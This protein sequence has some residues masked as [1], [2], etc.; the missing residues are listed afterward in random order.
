MSDRTTRLLRNGLAGNQVDFDEFVGRVTPLL[1][2][3]AKRCTRSLA[4]RGLDP[5]DVVQHV[6]MKC[7]P[8]LSSIQPKEGRI[9]PVVVK[10]LSQAIQRRARDLMVAAGRR[11]QVGVVDG[12]QDALQA[13]TRGVVT[14]VLA[15]EQTNEVLAAIE[16]LDDID[17]D[18]LV[19]LSIEQIPLADAAL[20]LGITTDAAKQRH[21]RA[22]ARLLAQLQGSLFD[23]LD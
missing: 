4:G 22:R 9:T 18:A 23:E 12:D 21:S 11:E 3:V 16:S 7:L 2:A 8:K 1:L 10:Y 13:M 5:E 17:R 20:I 19:M 6:W 15:V 14:R